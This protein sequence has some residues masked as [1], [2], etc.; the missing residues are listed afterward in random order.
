MSRSSLF[1]TAALVNISIVLVQQ[2]TV[3]KTA[4][5]I[6]VIARA[7]TVKI[8]LQQYRKGDNNGSGVIIDRR[9]VAAGD[10]KEYLY[11]LVTNSHVVCGDNEVE[12]LLCPSI[13][14][15][16]TFFLNLP[17]GQKYQT[18]AASVKILDSELDIAIIQFRSSRQ[19]AVARLAAPGNLK[20][21]DDV[22]TSGFPY[23]QPDFSFNQ[24]KA[25][26]VVNK[27]L[28]GDRGGY[29]IAYNA[30]TLSGMS[31]GGVFDVDAQLVAIHGYGDR[32]KRNT[33]INS[34]ANVTKKIGMNRGIPVRWLLQ[35]LIALGINLGGNRS[36]SD[37]KVARPQVPESADEYYIAGFNIFL[38]PGNNF[39]LGKRKAI[40][41]FTKAIQL[42]PQYV[43]AYFMRA[44]IYGQLEEFQKSLT[45]YDQAIALNPKYLN[46]YRNRGFL[47]ITKFNNVQGALADFNQAILLDPKDAGEYDNRGLLKKVYLDDAQ[48]AMIDFNQAISIN[49]KFANAYNHRGVLKIEKFDDTSG[50]LADYNQ[51]INFDPRHA[52]AYSNRGNLKKERLSNYQEALSDYNQAIIINSKYANAYNNRGLLKRDYLSDREG[53]IADFRLAAKFFREQGNSKFLQRAINNLKSLNATE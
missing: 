1:F 18:S 14:T 34:T 3:A 49:P 2:V 6:E 45:D 28:I 33:E 37:I 10:R 7:T 12:E 16:E 30:P 31:G 11:T 39:I 41:S 44:V 24:G 17:D 19:Y 32:V 13:P 25:V 52:E 53:A 43:Y 35:N 40:Q 38:D 27:R 8:Q 20:A 26:A 22:Y 42:N 21:T 9:A 50:A 47:R 23:G 29:T 4:S 48:G 15:K 36:I 51:A 5:E 46:A